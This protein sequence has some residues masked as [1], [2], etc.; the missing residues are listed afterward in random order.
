M[1]N[2]EFKKRPS[3]QILSLALWLILTFT[4][5]FIASRFMPGEWYQGLVKPSWN[6]PNWI[7]GPVWTLLYTLMAVAVWLVW[8]ERHKDNIK[9]AIILYA[10]QL[11]LNGIWSFIFFGQEL[12][13][14]A[15]VDILILLILIIATLLNFYKIN[16]TAGILL[17]P[18][19][20]WVGFASALNFRLWQ[21]NG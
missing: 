7:F 8:K 9:S 21:L 12:I 11:F 4:V 18:Y 1:I 14:L 17:I 2:S 20:I 16:R 5:S 3:R 6:P 15:L 10:L 13:G 19:L